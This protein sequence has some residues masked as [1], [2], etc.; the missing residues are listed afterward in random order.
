[1]ERSLPVW[2]LNLERSTERRAFMEEQLL[3]LQL[4]YEI[5][6]AVDGRSLSI[7]DKKQ[8][9]RKD[10]MRCCD[11]ELSPGEVGCA[12]SHIRMWQRLIRECIDEVLILEDD[13]LLGEMFLHVLRH[14]SR[15]PADW[16]LINFVT[17][18]PHIP[19]G[20]PICD[21]YKVCRFQGWANRT[22]A[23]LINRRGAQKLL[24]HAF[25]IRW[26]ADGITGR[27][28]I[29]E[30]VSYGIDPNVVGLNHNSESEIWKISGMSALR[31]T[32]RAKRRALIK[33]MINGLNYLCIGNDKLQR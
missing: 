7:E 4:D 18:A 26:P 33:K 6:A 8:Y 11:R 17:D 23:Y 5:V 16:E 27:I 2:V 22:G 25:P 3:R 10:A 12:L 15:F 1:M 20:N 30:L 24:N 21:I 14:R 13:V 31:T 19:F 9:S 32:A 28:Y 29:T